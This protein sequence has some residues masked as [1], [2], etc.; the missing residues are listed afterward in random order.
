MKIYLANKFQKI[1]Q[2]LSEAN[3]KQK[4]KPKK[5]KI[6][7]KLLKLIKLFI[8]SIIEIKIKINHIKLKYF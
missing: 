2:L 5:I 8:K 7:L 6:F 3:K 4:I 1:Y